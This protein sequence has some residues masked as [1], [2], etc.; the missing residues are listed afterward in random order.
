MRRSP[1]GP[2]S[3]RLGRGHRCSGIAAA[4]SPGKRACGRPN[5]GGTWWRSTPGRALALPGHRLHGARGRKG[6]ESPT[7]EMAGSDLPSL[8]QPCG[9]GERGRQ[10][11]EDGDGG[12]EPSF[13][14]AAARGWRE[15]ANLP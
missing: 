1:R 4:R 6:S 7:A 14:G 9:D 10:P 15:R 5:L 11:R 2:S 13:L 3:P 12:V 8:E